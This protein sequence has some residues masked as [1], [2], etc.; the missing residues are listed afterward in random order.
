MAAVSSADLNS[1]KSWTPWD[2]QDIEWDCHGW[3][4]MCFIQ[5]GTMEKEL[6]FHWTEG[7]TEILC[8]RGV[9][10]YRIVP[11]Q[12]RSWKHFQARMC[13]YALF[14]LFLNLRKATAAHIQAAYEQ[15]TTSIDEYHFGTTCR[16]DALYHKFGVC[17]HICLSHS[18]VTVL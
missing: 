4:R 15:V 5:H 9:S 17:P 8:S 16:N 1:R 14:T 13:P 11:H 18:P 10:Y 6:C 3:S 12:A 7:Q 2:S